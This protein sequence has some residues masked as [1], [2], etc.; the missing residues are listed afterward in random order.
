MS[1]APAVAP[2]AVLQAVGANPVWYHTLEL[3]PGVVTP[4]HI[5]LRGVA[6]RLLPAALA[7]S[8]ALDVGTF[9]GFWAFELERRG[10]EVT[11]IDLP[12]AEAAE[13]PPA[14]RARIERQVRE[15]NVELGRGFA[16][17]ATA[18]GSHVRRVECDVYRLAPEIIGGA[19]DFAFAG[20][21]LLHLRDP[22]RALQRIRDALV[23]GGTLIVLEPF[24]IRD[25]V[26]SPRRP[27]ANFR[28][29][30]S[31]FAWWVPN[32]SA[33]RAWL[34]AAGFEQVRR[35]GL[36]RPPATREMRQWLAGYVARRPAA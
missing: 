24:S 20:A 5:D 32:L 30:W 12:R 14:N 34:V 36:Y 22:V 25:T 18:L 17:A 27:A 16:V 23:P 8:R 1:A 35:H 11:A 2:E 15:R 29:S 21:I 3:A 31:D 33:L 13:W 28:G 19:V 7:G 26:T 6:P 4:G 10:A 9:D